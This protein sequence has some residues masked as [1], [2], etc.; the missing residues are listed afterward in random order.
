[1]ITRSLLYL[2]VYT[3]PKSK[4]LNIMQQLS[5]SGKMDNS[6]KSTQ[7]SSLKYI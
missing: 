4:Y 6:I 1:M 5:K 3:K 7:N 2:E